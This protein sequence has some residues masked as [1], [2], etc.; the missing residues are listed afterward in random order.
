MVAS[1]KNKRASADAEEIVPSRSTRKGRG[2]IQQTRDQAS[3]R[4]SRPYD[5]KS[6]LLSTNSTNI[7][8]ALTSTTKLSLI[9]RFSKDSG[10]KD[11]DDKRRQYYSR[12]HTESHIS[13]TF[14]NQ[15]IF[16]ICSIISMSFS[17]SKH[18][19]LF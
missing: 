6:S 14:Q 10:A 11:A 12:T 3:N 4:A 18:L 15:F 16:A 17:F 19:K 8:S 7:D 13:Q 9:P 5:S 2:A 1:P